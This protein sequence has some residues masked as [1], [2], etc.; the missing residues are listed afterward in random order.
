MRR[1]AGFTASPARPVEAAGGSGFIE[2]S[3]INILRPLPAY[4]LALKCAAM[5]LG[6]GLFR[7][8]ED[9]RYLLRSM[10]LASTEDA[11]ASLRGYLEPRQLPSDLGERLESLAFRP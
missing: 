1:T 3:N 10:N 4:A 7:E 9:V 6:P 11:M 2:L 5:R 8:E